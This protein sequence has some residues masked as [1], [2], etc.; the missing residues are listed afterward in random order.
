MNKNRKSYSKLELGIQ[1]WIAYNVHFIMSGDFDS[2]CETFGCIAM[3]L[4]LLGT[5]LNLAITANATIAM[6]YDEKVRTCAHEMSKFRTREKEIAHI[7][8]EGQARKTRSPS[9]MWRSYNLRTA[10]C[11]RGA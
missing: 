1:A 3:Q 7:L 5:F 11:G 4:T 2:A 6:K 9:R 8:K 10:K